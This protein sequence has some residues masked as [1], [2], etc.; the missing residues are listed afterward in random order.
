MSTYQKPVATQID[1]AA[2]GIYM[3][4]GAT[5]G[6]NSSSGISVTVSK[7][8]EQSW[9]DSGQTTF[10]VALKGKIG[11]RIK[12]T[13][14]FDKE[15]T[16]AWG[17]NGSC[18]ISSPKAVFDIHNPSNSFEITA[19]GKTGLGVTDSYAENVD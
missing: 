3:A 6:D 7:K 14:T 10:K 13:I 11:N 16:N 18:K 12:L 2:E 19:Q 5:A 8:D 1:T 15:I 4:S 9:G 17:G